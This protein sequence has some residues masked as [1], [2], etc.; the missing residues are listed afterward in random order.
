MVATIAFGMGID[1]TRRA[2]PSPTS[3]RRNRWKAMQEPAAPGRDNGSRP[4]V[5]GLWPGRCRCCCDG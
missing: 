3:T 2:F 1:K 4:G 5:A